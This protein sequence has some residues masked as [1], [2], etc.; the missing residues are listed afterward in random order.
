VDIDAHPEL[1]DDGLGAH[2]WVILNTRVSSLRVVMPLT[3][4]IR[5][6]R[7]AFSTSDRTFVRDLYE[8]IAQ[9]IDGPRR[10]EQF[11]AASPKL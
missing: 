8:R 2:E 5:L 11:I 7:K 6:R 3:Y 10:R 9:H 4:A 1:E